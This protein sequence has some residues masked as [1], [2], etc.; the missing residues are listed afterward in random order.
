MRRTTAERLYE[1]A[2]SA[3]MLG[4]YRAWED[5]AVEQKE[6]WELEAKAI[7][8]DAICAR[9]RTVYGVNWRKLEQEI[10]ERIGENGD[11]EKRIGNIRNYLAFHLG[12]SLDS[13]AAG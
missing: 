10:A 13:G 8:D 5:L 6:A 12:V 3:K 1:F 7:V 9:L 2:A 4:A 11:F